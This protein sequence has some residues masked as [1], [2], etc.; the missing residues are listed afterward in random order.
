MAC[1]LEIWK[2][3][4][5]NLEE[6]IQFLFACLVRDLWFLFL[7]GGI[8]CGRDLFSRTAVANFKDLLRFCFGGR[9]EHRLQSLAT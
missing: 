8:V 3:F 9:P 1:S 6:F 5:R 4:G 7:L 2:A